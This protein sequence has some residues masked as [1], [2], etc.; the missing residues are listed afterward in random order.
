MLATTRNYAS[1]HFGKNKMRNKH[2][3]L[4]THG[5]VES[6]DDLCGCQKIMKFAYKLNNH[7]LD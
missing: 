7:F 3:H 5:H 4:L 6:F 2:N 1:V